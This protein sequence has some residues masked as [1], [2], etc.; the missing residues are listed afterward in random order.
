MTIPTIERFNIRCDQN[1]EWRINDET[2]DI[3]KKLKEV[4][5]YF[6]FIIFEKEDIRIV[7][8]F[9]ING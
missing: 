3:Y 1:K 8:K 4:K 9:D 6:S 7:Y 2:D 5:G